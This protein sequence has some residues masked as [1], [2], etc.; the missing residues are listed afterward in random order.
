MSFTFDKPTDLTGLGNALASGQGQ[1]QLEADGNWSDVQRAA[2]AA[3]AGSFGFTDANQ[4]G[5]YEY[6]GKTKGP[7][8]DEKRKLVEDALNTAANAP[9]VDAAESAKDDANRVDQAGED[10]GQ[11]L[12]MQQVFTLIPL[13]P[14]MAAIFTPLIEQVNAEFQGAAQ[15]TVDTTTSV[16]Q[17]VQ[18]LADQADTSVAQAKE[19]GYSVEEGKKAAAAADDSAEA[20]GTAAENL[21]AIAP[22]LLGP[23]MSQSASLAP[24]L[25][26]SA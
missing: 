25:S 16:V 18:D 10:I 22:I 4:D 6:D 19:A 14:V 24:A 9:A 20:A 17:G 3:L 13:D 11:F 1:G 2:F 8:G 26:P 7:T 5:S 23:Q 12:E 21:N 15:A